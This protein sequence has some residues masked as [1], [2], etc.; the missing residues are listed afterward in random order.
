MKTL[1]SSSHRYLAILTA[2]QMSTAAE[3][4]NYNLNT[5]LFCGTFGSVLVQQKGAPHHHRHIN[6]RNI[7]VCPHIY[8]RS[9]HQYWIS[10]RTKQWQ[11]NPPEHSVQESP[12]TDL[13][14][15]R[16]PK[17]RQFKELHNLRKESIPWE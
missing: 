17:D 5:R 9:T 2:K 4:H 6:R 14:S 12:W 16:Y 10:Q 7:D 8:V 13:W 3:S 11:S 1:F 15:S